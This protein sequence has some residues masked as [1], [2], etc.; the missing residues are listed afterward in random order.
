MTPTH[1]KHSFCS[2]SGKIGGVAVDD[3]N[4]DELIKSLPSPCC[5]DTT[6]TGLDLVDV[7]VPPRQMWTVAFPNLSTINA[8]AVSN[9]VSFIFPAA[10]GG[11]STHAGD[12]CKSTVEICASFSFSHTLQIPPVAAL[13]RNFVPG[14]ASLVRDTS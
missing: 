6:H 13:C 3:K 10:L 8:G 14:S 5:N 2:R 11:F 9:F 1:P 12:E 4:R 7:M